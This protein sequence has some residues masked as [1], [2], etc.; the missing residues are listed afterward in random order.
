MR[1]MLAPFPHQLFQLGILAVGQHD[2]GHDVK[3]AGRLSRQTLA[4]EPKRAAARRVCRHRKLDRSIQRRD[5]HLG[6]EHGLVKRDREFEPEVLLLDL[7][8][9]MRRDRDRDQHVARRAAMR[10][11]HALALETDLLAVLNAGRNLELDLPVGGQFEP[12]RAAM[13]GFVQRD[14]CARGD[15]LPADRRADVLGLELGTCAGSPA[16]AE[17]AGENVLEAREPGTTRPARA[18]S[19]RAANAFRAPGEALEV[20]IARAERV[21]TR[22][23]PPAESLEA[24]EARLAVRAD[25]AAVELL[26]LVGIADDLVRTV[27]LG[28]FIGRLRILAGIRVQLLRQLAIRL[29]DVFR[30]RRL[31]HPQHLIGVTHPVAPID[32]PGPGGPTRSASMWGQCGPCATDRGGDGY[33]RFKSRRLRTV[34]LPLWMRQAAPFSPEFS[35]PRIKLP[36]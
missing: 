16:P 23:R 1:V 8:Q 27:E 14:G 30:A 25:L 13:R 7:E 11:R 5:P 21:S 2:L 28:E 29:L 22:A 18:T 9:R 3:I 35:P 19:A 4:F 15:V 20:A 31:G 32:S 34:P 36:R 6:A 10:R 24:L 17:D 12:S 26:A 33:D